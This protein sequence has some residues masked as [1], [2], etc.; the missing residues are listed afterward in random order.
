MTAFWASLVFVVLAEMGDKTQLLAMAF[1]TRYRASTVLW[2]VFAATALNHALAVAVGNYL[3]T[4]VPLGTIQA[5]AAV[6]FILFGLWTIRGDK[7]DGEDKRF[8]FSP[9]WTVAIAFFIAEMGDKTQLAT[10]ALA[11]NYQSPVLT[12][13]GTNVGML[14]AD[15]IGIVV[16]ITLYKHIPE[17]A[18]KWG[19]ALIFMAF[20]IY[21]V[22]EN[23]SEQI[24]TPVVEIASLFC[25]GIVG[26]FLARASQQKTV[27]ETE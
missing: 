4:I 13:L 15:A 22:H 8:S 26:F 24:L 21:G 11:A 17:Q 14:I 1:A 25:L 12:W 19:A 2:A 7:L 18:V 20:G 3:T 27:S 23:V 16:G 5:V 9:F 10:V 6:S